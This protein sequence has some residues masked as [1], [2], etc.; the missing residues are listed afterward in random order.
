MK[1]S[2]RLAGCLLAFVLGIAPSHAEFLYAP[3][4]AAS[5]NGFYTPTLSFDDVIY[6]YSAWDIFYAPH[7][8]GNYPD[9]FAPYGGVPGAVPGEWSPEQLSAANVNPDNAGY[10]T[11]PTAPTVYNPGNPYAF[12]D[13]RNATITQTAANTAFI[14]GPDISGNIYT[15]QQKTAYLLQNN[16]DYD[17][18]GTVILQFQ[19]DGTLVDFSTIRLVWNDGANDHTIRATEAEYLREY[20]NSGSGHWSASAGYAN[21]VAVQWDLSDAVD[22]FGNPVTAYRIYLESETSSMSFQKVDLVTSDTYEAG[23]PIS[24]T[25]VGAAGNWTQAANWELKEASGLTLPQSN[26][27]IRFANS[28][29]A[30]LTLN[31]GHHNVGEVIFESPADVIINSLSNYRITSNTGVTTR[32]TAT[33][34]YTI[35]SDFAFGALNFFEI[36]AGTVTMNGV[37]SGAYGMVKSGEGTLVLAGNNTFSG[38]LGVQDGTVVIRGANTYSG[39]TTLV[40]GRLVLA[41]DAGTTG[42]LGNASTEIAV[43]ADAGLY[44]YVGSGTTLRAELMLDGDRLLSRNIVLAAGDFEKRLE[45]MNTTTG[46]TFSGNVLFGTASSNPDSSESAA[47]EVHLTAE[48][49]GDVAIFSGQLY[50]GGASKRVIIDGA[51]TVRYTGT[52]KTYLNSTVVQSGRL[53]LDAGTSYTGGGAISVSSGGELRVNGVLGGGGLL[54]VDG[55]LSGTGTVQRGFTLADGGVMSPGASVGTLTVTEDVVFGGGGVYRWELQDVDSGAGT[56]WDMLMIDGTLTINSTS[57]SR[58]ILH[59]TSLNS[60]GLPG[61]MADFSTLGLYDWT[62]LTAVDGIIGFSADKFQLDLLPFDNPNS[63]GF[64][65]EQVS[66]GDGSDSLVLHYS[67]VPVPEPGRVTLLLASLMGTALRRRRPATIQTHAS[68][69]QVL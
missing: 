26:G 5:P 62:L 17:Q 67:P 56:G 48:G 16:P 39:N 43:G 23:I 36:N 60:L 29:A 9:I 22:L 18:L 59:V 3:G 41:A 30:A 58:F 53:E 27:N 61:Q 34:S 69:P 42:A 32:S 20:R 21:R 12:W 44:A 28:S 2:T 55:V 19:T 25:W 11:F 38:F 47:G 14:V 66:H 52:A 50:G 54:T 37:I 51:G 1:C 24:A 6:E 64:T 33:G 68:T 40:N 13:N 65:L 31:D 46:G 15:F 35:N 8:H 45:V 4:A 7:T 63:G 10:G 49:A 57:A